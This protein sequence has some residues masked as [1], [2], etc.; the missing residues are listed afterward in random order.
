MKGFFY[1][2]LLF[3]ATASFTA[4]VLHQDVRNISGKVIAFDDSLPVKGV[5]VT[6]KGTRK[7]TGTQADGTFYIR[8]QAPQDSILVLSASGF[9]TQELKLSTKFNYD[10]VLKRYG[11]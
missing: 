4:P 7:T 10:V 1:A 8:V 11:H 3:I 9:Q 5:S 2:T 6:T